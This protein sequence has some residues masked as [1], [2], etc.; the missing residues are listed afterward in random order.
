MLMMRRLGNTLPPPPM[1][2]F[3]EGASGQPAAGVQSAAGGW[4]SPANSGGIGGRPRRVARTQP[5]SHLCTRLC[6][7]GAVAVL[8][9]WR[10]RK[11]ARAVLAFAFRLPGRPLQCWHG[12]LAV[13][14]ETPSMSSPIGV[15]VS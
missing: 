6:A 10:W 11:C 2:Q 5:G 8:T 14:Q 1:S 15:L 7:R 9:N 13:P 12:V 3:G 4:R